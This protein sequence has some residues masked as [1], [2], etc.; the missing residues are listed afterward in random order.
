MINTKKHKG[1]ALFLYPNSEGLGGVPNGVALL[2]GCLKKAGYQTRC[3]DTTFLNSPPLTHFQRAKHGYFL[4][5]DHSQYW[6]GWKE[7]LPRKI[8]N[9][10]V[11]AVTEFRPDFIAVSHVDIGFL[12]MGPL[13]KVIKNQFNIPIIAG[14]ITCTSSPSL[15]IAN[16]YIDAICVGEGEEA[17]IEFAEA[18]ITGEDY[19]NIKNLWVKKDGKII[20][21]P[22]R[23]LIDMDNLPFQDWSIF[24]ERHY[25]KPYCGEFHRT[26]FIEMARGCHF[27]CT[28]CVNNTLRRMYKGLGH[29]IR[30][31]SIDRTLDE[32]CY[33]KNLY[34]L[35]LIFFI[36][37]NF[38]GMQ[39]DRFNYFCAE[40]K[41]RIGLPFYIQTRSET[42]KESYIKKLKEIN[43]STIAIGVE[44]GDEEFRKKYMNRKM[45][46]ASLQKAF[47]I[48]HK[49]EIRTTAN[50]IIG[51]PHE[52]EEMMGETIKLLRSLKPK[53]V[54]INY[55]TPYRGIAMRDMAVKEGII[56][57]DH[58]IK[59]TNVCL[60]MPQFK[61]ERICHYYD[62][63][64]K[65][66][67][68]ELKFDFN[69]K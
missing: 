24:D 46:N 65:Y 37:D 4:Q 50:I 54:S 62:N 43:I 56:S 60:D 13:L 61:A 40:Y 20:S 52:L 55:F 67:E 53:S 10:L 41:K 12:Y 8:P 64:K 19:S 25:Y 23:P 44:S 11:D 26:A 45:S 14:G 6:G 51:M 63:L 27:N 68:G 35:E 38:L 58:V 59:E 15:V 48:V 2:S 32:I 22:L 57:E 66:V 29:F 47:D 39:E 18:V 5:A 33:L 7:D 17:L 16:D 30:N 34:K 21:N 69:L 49:Y 28:Y 36:D 42:V 1:K 9:L 3:F 31:R